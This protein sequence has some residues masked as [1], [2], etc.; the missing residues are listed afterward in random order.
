MQSQRSRG[1]K[2][3]LTEVG[4]V[5]SERT[6]LSEETHSHSRSPTCG[7]REKGGETGGQRPLRAGHPRASS[8]E[9]PGALDPTRPHPRLRASQAG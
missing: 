7:T 6:P 4:G 8:R 2:W 9:A 3:G 1:K 5:D